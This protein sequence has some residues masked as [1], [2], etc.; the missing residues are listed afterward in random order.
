[1]SAS[2]LRIDLRPSPRLAALMVAAHAAAATGAAIALPGAAGSLIAALLLGLGFA[3]AWN[4]AL[5]RAR[6]SIRAIE[7]DAAG[8][9]LEAADGE[10]IPAL[11]AGRRYVGRWLVTLPLRRPSRL[12]IL[13][14]PGMLAP[15][16]FRRLRLWALWGKLPPVAGVQL[17]S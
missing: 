9:V 13:V 11:P 16:P 12:T 4:R 15:A 6:K 14:T 1:L 10:R 7:I 2:R 17:A 3:S 5:L 8:L